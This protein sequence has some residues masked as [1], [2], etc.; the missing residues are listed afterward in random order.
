MWMAPPVRSA[1]AR[2]GAL[3]RG[4]GAVAGAGDGG[5]GWADVHARTR[6]VVDERFRVQFGGRPSGCS[7]GG[8]PGRR[9]G[10]GGPR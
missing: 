5:Q 2:V 6:N 8:L 1:L 4:G 10:A 9:A 3:A 7:A